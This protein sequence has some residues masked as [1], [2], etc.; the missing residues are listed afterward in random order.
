MAIGEIKVQGD[1]G[2]NI[3]SGPLTISNGSSDL[4]FRM[5]LLDLLGGPLAAMQFQVIS[6]I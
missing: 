6:L 2:S 3:L 5:L 1:G 4:V